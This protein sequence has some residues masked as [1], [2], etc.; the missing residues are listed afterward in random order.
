VLVEISL[1]LLTSSLY[2]SLIVRYILKVGELVSMGGTVMYTVTTAR[3]SMTGRPY[4]CMW[5]CLPPET[6]L[7]SLH[8][9]YVTRQSIVSLCSPVRMPLAD[10][11]SWARTISALST[12]PRVR[13]F[14]FFRLFHFVTCNAPTSLDANYHVAVH[15]RGRRQVLRA[16]TF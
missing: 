11:V 15:T 6:V 4:I 16:K 8:K 12:H 5:S 9:P 7:L 13:H 1:Y 2:W 10:T 14:F 3:P